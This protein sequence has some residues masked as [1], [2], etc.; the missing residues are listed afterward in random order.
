MKVTYLENDVLILIGPVA[1][2]DPSGPE[3]YVE[4]G[5]VSSG[6]S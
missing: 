5:E 1:I 6:D 4:L 2:I 3:E